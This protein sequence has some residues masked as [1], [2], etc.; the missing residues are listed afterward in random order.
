MGC[1]FTPSERRA[2]GALGVGAGGGRQ[3]WPPKASGRQRTASS[4]H[5]DPDAR[6]LW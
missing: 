1:A 6:T 3:E 4:E 2:P 5:P